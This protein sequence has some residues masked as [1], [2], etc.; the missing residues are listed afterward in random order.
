[1]TDLKLAHDLV[2]EDLYAEDSLSFI[3]R[4]FVGKLAGA[5][6]ALADRLTAA[7][8]DPGSLDKKAESD[9]ILELAPHLEAF[10]GSLFGIEAQ[11]A[12]LAKSHRDLDDLYSCKRLFVQRRAIKAHKPEDAA[13]FNG[14]ALEADLTVRFGGTFDQIAYARNVTAWLKDEEANAESLDLAA[15][16]A[17][18]AAFTHDGHERHFDD[19]LFKKPEKIDFDHLTPFETFDDHGIEMMRMNSK[20]CHHYNRDAFALTDHGADLI[21]GLDE[22]NYCVICHDRGRDYCSRGMVEKDSK[23]FTHSPLGVPQN[24]CPLEEKISEMHKAKTEGNAVAA[25]AVIVVDNPTVAATGHRICNDCMKACIYQKQTPV[26]IPQVETRVLKDVLNLPW[27]FEIYSMLTRW[28][29]LNI[30]RPLSKPDTGR[31]VL[32]VGAGPA[33]YS[34]AHF[35]MNEGHT[36]VVIDGLKIEPLA[37]EISGVDQSGQRCPFKPIKDILP[38][39]LIAAGHLVYIQ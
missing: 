20:E 22:A 11:L 4:T 15:R 30:K 23:K 33:G 14:P 9:L 19:I 35:L 32:I 36:T 1:M 28:N 18:W 21:G 16:Y 12:A 7:R 17:A 2:F 39:H 37:P 5:D 24:G 38:F 6:G 34:L 13:G 25:L 3:D 26:N 29:P 10:I 27:G 31:K 8:A